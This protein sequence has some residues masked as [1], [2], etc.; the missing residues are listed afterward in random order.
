MRLGH[1]I[2]AVTVATVVTLGLLTVLLISH[3]V[4]AAL[5][6]SVQDKEIALTRVA[7][8][9]MANDV[10]NGNYLTVQHEM[11]AFLDDEHLAYVFLILPDGQIM[12][13]LPG[14][15]ASDLVELNRLQRGQS[16]AL[17]SFSSDHGKIEDV[18]VHLLD[19][20]DSELHIGFKEDYIQAIL[21]QVSRTI[22]ILTVIGV[23]LAAAAAGG[24]GKYL[25]S[26]I[27]KLTKL[28]R[29]IAN[30]HLE[31]RVNIIAQ[32]EVGELAQSF[33]LMV[34]ALQENMT[35]LQTAQEEQ[36]IKNREL[37]AL[38]VVAEI[39]TLERDIDAVL[40]DALVKVSGT[41][42]LWGGWISLHSG[43][44]DEGQKVIGTGIKQDEIP[45]KRCDF[46]DC[47]LINLQDG[48]CLS[49]ENLERDGQSYHVTG[50]PIFAGERIL[51][52]MHFLSEHDL[53]SSDLATLQSIGR[54]LGTLIENFTLWNELKIRE[55]M[56]SQ[57]LEKIMVAQEDE[58]KRIARELHDETSQSLAALAMRLKTG[59]G[60]LKRDLDRAE[61]LLEESKNEAVR[62][63]RELHNIIYHL[64]P[65]LLD[66][67][68]LVPALRWLAESRD[69]GQAV[70]VEIKGEWSG[71]RINAQAETA[72]FRIGQET[73]TNAAKYSGATE[74]EI[75]FEQGQREATL[76]IADNGCGFI[77]NEASLE[78]SPGQKPLGILG[79][80][81]RASLLGG[82]VTI[83][84]T[85]GSGTTV[86]AT[87]PVG[88]LESQEGEKAW[89]K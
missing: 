15:I 80:M 82:R 71:D 62:I 6:Q 21:G 69:W 25:S 48:H 32:D 1:K 64:R 47:D 54:Q 35:E 16:Y 74:L 76:R 89:K 2:T 19:G 52:A 68:G 18:G 30:G 58:R 81:E 31:H 75:E 73:I 42:D 9:D 4:S 29:E 84:T 56:V 40:Q 7:A 83:S 63:M 60:W 55:K 57:L 36:L 61:E 85:P 8:N 86:T 3:V 53:I 20:I 33:N 77:L 17:R 50:V 46:C 22:F 51:G 70:R 78:T 79:M 37:T 23:F 34:E 65:T 10:L 45:C 5:R 41:L 87:I 43:S 66:D 28:T 44:V 12:H 67:L 49:L 11:D 13:T 24:L 88:M 72:L 59:Q 14:T 26:P 27:E 39:V 38:N